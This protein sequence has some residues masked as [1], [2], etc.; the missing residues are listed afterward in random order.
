MITIGAKEAKW[1]IAWEGTRTDGRT[2]RW[3]Q[4]TKWGNV[5]LNYLDKP[6]EGTSISTSV[7]EKLL[8]HLNSSS[9]I[10]T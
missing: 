7:I 6:L 8:K 5:Y 3:N 1:Y 9:L 4:E 2:R 10:N